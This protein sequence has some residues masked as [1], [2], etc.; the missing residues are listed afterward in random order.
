MKIR[1]GFVGNSSSSSF[2]IDKAYLSRNMIERIEQHATS[3]EF[4]ASG[5][6]K[7]DAWAVYEE[8]DHLRVC[9]SMDNFDMEDFLINA[10]SVPEKALKWS[11]I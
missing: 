3:P 10:V 6:D 1:L 8:D 2:L 9:T 11:E 4:M 5:N 7:D